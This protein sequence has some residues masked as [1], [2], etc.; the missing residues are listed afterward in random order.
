MHI[1]NYACNSFLHTSIQVAQTKD[2]A[3]QEKFRD[4]TSKLLQLTPPGPSIWLYH[5]HDGEVLRTINFSA[6]MDFTA[7]SKY[8]SWKPYDSIT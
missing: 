3:L 7:A 2:S 6:F 4:I 1:S 8:F 5:M